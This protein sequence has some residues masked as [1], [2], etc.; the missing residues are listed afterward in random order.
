[1]S[2]KAKDLISLIIISI[3]LFWLGFRAGEMYNR[4]RK[5]K[6]EKIAIPVPTPTPQKIFYIVEKVNY[7]AYSIVQF[8][9]QKDDDP[10]I[11][12]LYNE[13]LKHLLKLRD[14]Q[15]YTFK[16]ERVY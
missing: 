11:V 5:M 16:G 6:I 12:F 7:G 1:M 13:K 8:Y 3:L 9:P 14:L 15:I 10:I 4:I 2:K